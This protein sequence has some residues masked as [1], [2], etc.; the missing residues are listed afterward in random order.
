MSEGFKKFDETYKAIFTALMAFS[1][2][3]I[4]GL[5]LVVTRKTGLCV[6]ELYYHVSL[7]GFAGSIFMSILSA[8]W[9]LWHHSQEGAGSNSLKYR[10]IN[11]IKFK[12]ITISLFSFLL[13]FTFF[14]VTLWEAEV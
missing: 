3:G 10:D 14:I 11:K 9:G 2:S 5:L 12:A 13:G 7:M 8:Y 4:G 6:N 1:S